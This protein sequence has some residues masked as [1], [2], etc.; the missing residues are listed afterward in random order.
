MLPADFLPLR[1]LLV[2]GGGFL[3]LVGCNTEQFICADMEDK[4]HLNEIAYREVFLRLPIIECLAFNVER[5]AQIF[6]GHGV[7]CAL[8]ANISEYSFQND[9]TSNSLPTRFVSLYPL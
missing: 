5:T 9:I 1:P 2:V 4:R 8:G 7:S 3:L 6:D